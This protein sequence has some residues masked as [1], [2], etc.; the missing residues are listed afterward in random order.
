MAVARL[1]NP[2]SNVP[3]LGDAKAMWASSLAAANRTPKT[4]RTYLDAVGKLEKEVTSFRPID[5]ITRSDHEA[6]IAT[7]QA[8]GMK[9]SSISTVYRSLRS[10]WKFVVEHNDLPV[11]KDPMNGMNAPKVD[12]TT[13]EFVT[14]A[15]LRAPL[16]T[17]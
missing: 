3:V 8:A 12:E 17:C 6:M 16:A 15:E 11:S 2:A 9:G 4:M 10:F 1:K 13:V 7:M 14:D 5:K